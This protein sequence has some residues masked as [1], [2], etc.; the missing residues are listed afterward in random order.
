MWPGDVISD[1]M[2]MHLYKYNHNLVILTHR[3]F[4]E[5]IVAR[6][7]VIMKML[8][9]HLWRNIED[10]LWGSPGTSL[11]TSSSWKKNF[12]GIIWNDLFISEVKLKLCS[13]IYDFQNGRHFGLATNFLPEV[14]PEDECTRKTAISISDIL[15][16]WSTLLLKYWRRCINFK[17]WPTLWPCDVINDVKSA[18]NITCTTRHPQQ[19]TSKILFVWYQSF[20]VKS[21]GQ[22]SWQT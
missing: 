3:K 13:I 6:F 11:M 18:W 15:S 8:L 1:V 9:F 7:L 16:F 4:N 17:I 21:S 12:F 14:I 5:D 22:T 10:R 20:I 19:C 2:N